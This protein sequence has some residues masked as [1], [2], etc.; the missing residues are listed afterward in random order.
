MR[1]NVFAL[2]FALMLPLSLFS[3][4]QEKTVWRVGVFDGSSGEFA[5]GSPHQ[6]VSFVAGQDQP[7]SGWYAFAPVA[8]L[9][10]AG[11]VADRPS[12]DRLL[13]HRQARQRLPT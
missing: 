6:A 11:D 5:D 7:R 1:R 4:S 3:E 8:P 9:G 12:R 13:N 10:K 2:V